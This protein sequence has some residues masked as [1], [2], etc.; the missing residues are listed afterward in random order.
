MGVGDFLCFLDL[1]AAFDFSPRAAVP[2]KAL[3][4][5]VFLCSW[6]LFGVSDCISP[7]SASAQMESV[8]CLLGSAARSVHQPVSARV[9]GGWFAGC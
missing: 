8:F 2:R 9:Q 3:F 5:F 1:P 7:G 4:P 6:T